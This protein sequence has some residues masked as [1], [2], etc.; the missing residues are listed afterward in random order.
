VAS[1]GIAGTAVL[2]TAGLA[3]AAMTGVA[4]L[5]RVRA[6]QVT[7]RVATT[8]TPV[9]RHLAALRPR[10]TAI[11]PI[12]PAIPAPDVPAPT[13]AAVAAILPSPA[14]PAAPPPARLAV[15]RPVAPAAYAQR[16]VGPV[17][18]LSATLVDFG[19]V[20]AGS[21][22][23]RRVTLTNAG[24]TPLHVG[25]PMVLM[26]TDLDLVTDCTGRTLVP[27]QHCSITVTFSPGGPTRLNAAVWLTDDTPQGREE[28]DV[29]GTSP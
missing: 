11:A 22:V 7:A 6:P 3:A 25:L 14:A 26:A 19:S 24:T 12:S 1:L 10:A 18:T 29:R 8:A 9:P 2:C 13:P 5:H 16:P 21:T 27:G 17:A 28:F 20:A 15:M 4:V 23:S